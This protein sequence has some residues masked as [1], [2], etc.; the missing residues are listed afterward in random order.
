M[1]DARLRFAADRAEI[2]QLQA[3]YMFALDW[4]DADAYAATFTEDG[5]LDWAQGVCHGREAIREEAKG[6]Y[7]HF[8]RMAAAYAPER[9]P[10]L[11][12][13]ISNVVLFIE[14]DTATGYAYWH[15]F[16]NDVRGRWPYLAGYGT[17]EDALRRV[18]GKWLF[19]RRKILNENMADRVAPEINP[20]SAYRARR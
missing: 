16:N 4:Q 2:E 20:V 9:R 11:R 19:T 3:E 14:G 1:D 10:R 6:M 7:A 12:H 13:F 5:V 15:E 8:A 18:D 17:Y